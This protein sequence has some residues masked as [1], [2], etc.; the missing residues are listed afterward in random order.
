MKSIR[1]LA[2]SLAPRLEL[3]MAILGFVYLGIYALQVSNSFDKQTSSNLEIA[4]WIVWSLFAI[5]LILKMFSTATLGKFFKSYWLEL[6]ALTVPFLRVLR[7]LRV[8]V[9][10]RGLKPFMSS[11]ISATGTYLVLLLPLTWFIGGVAVLDAENSSPSAH[12][13]N[14]PDALW[15]SLATITTVG[16]GDLYPIT[17]EGKA[18]AGILMLLG[19]ALFSTCAGILASWIMS[20]KKN[21]A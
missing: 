12:I 6:I 11:R 9:A 13:Q 15:W 14:L 3:P 1:K 7:V 20:E 5:D 8:L 4:S 19:I 16:Y 18:V 21:E 17:G 10:I 2:E